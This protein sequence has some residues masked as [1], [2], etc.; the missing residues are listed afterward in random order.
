MGRRALAAL[1]TTLLL[2][3]A[4]PARAETHALI[5]GFEDY[6]SKQ[7]LTGSHNDAADL[8]KVLRGRGVTDVTMVEEQHGTLAEV[9]AD[10]AAMVSRSKPGDLL[11]VSFS[12][13]GNRSPEK[14][15]PKHTPDGFEKGFL[16]PRYDE[17]KFP[18]EQLRDEHLYDLF[19]AASDKGLKII[20][21]AD[22]CHSGASVRAVTAKAAAPKFQRFE[23][24]GAALP[25]PPDPASVVRRP[26]IPGLTIYSAAD[27][28]QTIQEFL[29]DDEKHG[30]LSF[31]VARGLEG[32]AAGPSGVLT[33]GDLGRY[34][35]ANVRV[36]SDNTQIPRA[37]TPDPDAVLFAKGPATSDDGP[38][39]PGQIAPLGRVTLFTEA[40]P[41]SGLSGVVLSSDPTRLTLGWKAG[42]D[43]LNGH[44]DVVATGVAPEKLQDAVDARRV[45]DGLER[46]MGERGGAVPT[47][48]AAVGKPASDRYYLRDEQIGIEAANS[49]F[50]FLTVVDLTADGTVLF[51]WPQ[52]Q[53][54]VEWSS[55][56]P[57]S[58]KVKVTPP[59]GEDT[60]IFI[61]SDRALK[62]LH[63]ALAGLDGK[64]A[65]VPL[66]DAL[67]LWLPQ[68]RVKI[69][70]Q[71]VFTCEMLKE[72]GSCAV[73]PSP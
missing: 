46:A 6:V 18:E 30:A 40:T 1:T 72:D 4:V 70:L 11:F 62:D 69:G 61:E 41:P 9:E 45:L 13:H 51:L 36:L 39:A 19:K 44:G 22:A 42:G 10:W 15:E 34:V 47:S 48:V 56:H 68:A 27:E 55:D 21:V 33:E 35:L 53:D 25:P 32:K 66:Y 50:H 54:P 3:A 24:H 14:G 60:L 38:A 26:P 29:L 7:H 31:A 28:N 20:F 63:A 5:M 12:G 37:V 59:Y 8:A 43:V 67:R 23:T 2:A 64:H 71:S 57:W 52:H 16:L 58:F 73:S 17:I 65:A 49:A